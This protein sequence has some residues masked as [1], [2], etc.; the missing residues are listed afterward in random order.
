ML[1]VFYPSIKK[2]VVRIKKAPPFC[3]GTLGPLAVP[4][5]TTMLMLCLFDD[6]KVV[7]VTVH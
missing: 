6:D 3:S 7:M 2:F 5:L 4:T 1:Y